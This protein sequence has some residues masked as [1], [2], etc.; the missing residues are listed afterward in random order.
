M[1][2]L[3]AENNYV[4]VSC[5]KLD[6]SCEVL[7][8]KNHLLYLDTRDDSYELIPTN[9]KMKPYKIAIF[10]SGVERNLAGSKY[11]LRVDECKSAAYALLVYADMDYGKFLETVLR[12]VPYEVYLKYKE[13]LPESWR[14]R[15][16]TK[17]DV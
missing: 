9:P 15:A 3:S 11:N 5:G 7:S 10:F 14:K 2:V 13:R 17:N 16:G 8:K 6:Q 4:G 12:D 1:M